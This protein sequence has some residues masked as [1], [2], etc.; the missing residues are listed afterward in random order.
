MV[1]KEAQKPPKFN[2]TLELLLRRLVFN[3]HLPEKHSGTILETILKTILERKKETNAG[4]RTPKIK[5][6]TAVSRSDLNMQHML[7]MLYLLRMAVRCQ[8]VRGF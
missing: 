7:Y 3:R 1:P 6:D 8:G 2:K 4:Q 5:Q